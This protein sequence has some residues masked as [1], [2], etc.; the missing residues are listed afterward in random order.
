MGQSLVK[1]TGQV[2]DKESKLPLQKLMVINKRTS[3]GVFADAEGNFSIYAFQSDTILVSALGFRLKKICLKDSV[4]KDKYYIYI[5]LERLFYNLK[6]ISVFAPKSLKEIDREISKL[7]STKAN[8]KLSAVDAI[9]SPITFLYERFS[10]F[11]RSKRLVAE[12][13]DEDMKKEV[14]KDLFRLYIKHD[15]IDLSEEE[16]DAFIR[17]CNL[18]ESFIKNATQFE[19]VMAIKGKYETFKDR[20]K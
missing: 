6:E 16:F 17:Y 1:I 19:L 14:L 2:Y 4:A 8:R 10:K 15:I 13:E 12:W 5:P 20:W 3:N 18:S 9:G 11:E 7:D